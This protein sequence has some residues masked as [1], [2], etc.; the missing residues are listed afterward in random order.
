MREK[1]KHVE[2]ERARTGG[3]HDESIGLPLCVCVCVRMRTN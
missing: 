3:V 2:R 1:T